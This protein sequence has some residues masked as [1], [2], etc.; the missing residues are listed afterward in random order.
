[1]DVDRLF[2]SLKQTFNQKIPGGLS[3]EATSRLNRSLR[4]YI[5]QGGSEQ[6]ILKETY[7]SMAA[8]LKRNSEY[9][10]VPEPKKAVQEFRQ[11]MQPLT[12][13]SFDNMTDYTTGVTMP[14][15]DT[16][17]PL[18]KFERIKAR[19]NGLEAMPIAEMSPSQAA[20]TRPAFF[21]QPVAPTQPKDFLLKQD[22]IVKYRETE[23]NLVLNSK[24]R[25]W[26]NNTKENRYTF[27]VQ[28]DSGSKPQGTNAQVSI[29]NRFR[30]ITK[31]EFVKII[32]PVEGLDVIVQRDCQATGSPPPADPSLSFVSVL[33]TPYI[34]VVMDEM[35][36][37]NYGSNDKI[38][39]SLAICQYD[40]TWKSETTSVTTTTNRG[41]TLFF[42]KF[43]KAQRIYAP[44][45]L[46]SLQK[47]SF[48]ILNP[49]NSPLSTIPDAYTVSNLFIGANTN[50]TSCYKD[51]NSNYLFIRT[52]TWFPV[53]AFSILDRIQFA[54]LV[55]TAGNDDIVT[56]LQQ[57]QGH[58]VVQ[59]AYE[60]TNVFGRF[61]LDGTNT[62]GY[63][64]Y[65]IIRNR[66][67]DPTDGT[68]SRKLFTAEVTPNID[69]VIT[70][71]A[72]LN[73]SRQVQM[74]LRITVRE[75]DST[76]NLRPD[77]I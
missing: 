30:N 60:S 3:Q 1:M 68:I 72:V 52:Q 37:N 53:W 13:A 26:V 27:A 32:L 59:T 50:I 62:A 7:S 44:T 65:I 10:Q 28:L 45:P 34:T 54:G 57:E 43:I 14:E 16:E 69:V 63:A 39:K 22:D 5:Q 9:L 38:D 40:A 67:N 35:T 29:T 20:I 4:H 76:T 71:G 21:K 77:N 12:M 74:T 11:T 19:R 75:L 49:E 24:D 61:I 15:E 51:V 6:N 56:W 2:T 23:Y 47:M 8:W 42:P 73:L 46:A 18:D 31:I 48:S 33:A 41:Y 55:S 66:F 70:Q 58:V 64:N 25:D 36:G 17:S